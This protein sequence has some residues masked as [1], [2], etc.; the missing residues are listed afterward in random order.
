L[1]NRDIKLNLLKI[2]GA[3]LETIEILG[4]DNLLN[5]FKEV[6]SKDITLIGEYVSS[7]SFI[8]YPKSALVFYTIVENNNNESI[9][10][11][12]AESRE[13]FQKYRLLYSPIEKKSKSIKNSGDL[14]NILKELYNSISTS[15]LCDGEEGSVIYNISYNNLKSF[16]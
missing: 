6:M 16:N 12:G 11:T 3:W 8:K 5:E 14:V 4:K 7:N 15:Y 10:L 2:G 9:C 13:I 1:K